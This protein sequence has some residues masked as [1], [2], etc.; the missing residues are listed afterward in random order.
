MKLNWGKSLILFFI[1]FFAWVLYFVL[2][3]MRQ[4]D[5]LVSDDY[6]QKG[7]RY[8]E[9]IEI[10]RRSAAY[11]DSIQINTSG[12]AIQ[13]TLSK[14]MA[15]SDDSL[16]VYFF[17]SSDKTKDLIINLKMKDSPFQID[18]NLLVH[19]RF[20]VY[21]TWNSLNE[22]FSVTKTLDIE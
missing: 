7:A 6:Y 14:G 11:Q 10:N 15:A 16:Q 5:D 13:I 3:A 12:N 21:F 19:G 4:N 9:Q 2:F 8:S 22:K 17:R 20:M 1:I 18:K